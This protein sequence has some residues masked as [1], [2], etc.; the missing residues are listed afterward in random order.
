MPAATFQPLNFTEYSMEEMQTRAVAIRQ[1]MQRRRT[2]HQFSTRS[3]PREI[4][5]ECLIVAGTAPN[6]ANLQP[7]HFVARLI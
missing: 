1:E 7:W 6:G 4:I 2:V 5:E 3:V